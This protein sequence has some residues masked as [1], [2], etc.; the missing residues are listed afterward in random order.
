MKFKTVIFDLG[1]VVININTQQSFTAF[2]RLADLTEQEVQALASHPA[3]EQHERGLVSDEVFRNTIRAF[4]AS[5]LTD[6]AIDQAWNAMLL[7]IPPERL[8]LMAELRSRYHTLVLS[9][10]NNI[11]VQSFNRAINEI[12]G[13]KG[14]H[15]FVHKVYYSHE[16]GKRKPNPEIFDQVI[17]QEKIR[18]EQTLFLDDKLENVNA[19]KQM[20]LQAVQ[21]TPERDLIN[22]FATL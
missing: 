16:M 11:H 4:A 3:F 17:H 9:N 7:N 15:E 6:E 13:R 10:T 20:G 1:G 2:A 14:I 19:A 22:F 8:N 21:I 5:E 12:S 18:P